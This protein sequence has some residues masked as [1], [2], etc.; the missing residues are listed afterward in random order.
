MTLKVHLVDLDDETVSES[1]I[2]RANASET[3]SEVTK[4]VATTFNVPHEKMRLCFEASFRDVIPLN[5]PEREI[6]SEGFYKVG[7]VRELIGDASREREK[8]RR[9]DSDVC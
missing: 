4:A 5:S 3:V 9:C 1:R 8:V 6:K 7:R 2:I